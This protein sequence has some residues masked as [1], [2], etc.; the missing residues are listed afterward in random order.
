MNILN[1]KNKYI[2]SIWDN[3]EKLFGVVSQVNSNI[4]VKKFNSKNSYFIHCDL[5]DREQNLPNGK[6]S[7]VLARLY[8]KGTSYE[9]ITYQTAQQH[10]LRDTS[11]SDYVNNLTI[12]V[13]DVDANLF[14]FHGLPLEFEIELI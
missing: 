13:N 3:L 5:I 14:D 10:I 6:P 4:L 8:V 1:P 7:S 12:S 11:T 9:K 2:H